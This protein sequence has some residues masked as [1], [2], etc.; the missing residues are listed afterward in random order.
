MMSAA[1]LPADSAPSPAPLRR[2]HILEM[3]NG[4]KLVGEYLGLEEGK[5]R[6]RSETLGEVLVIAADAKVTPLPAQ[7][8]DLSANKPAWVAATPP[9]TPPAPPK[10]VI[11]ATQGPKPPPTWQ[12]I[13]EF[14]FGYQSS[15]VS[16]SDSYLRA[17]VA[18]VKPNY[19]YR[20]YGKYIYG[21][22]DDVKSVDR[23]ESGFA[24]RHDLEGRW[25][26]RNDITYQNDRLQK[27]DAEV[28]GTAGFNYVLFNRPKFKFNAGPGVGVRYREPELGHTGY[29]S[30]VDFSEELSWQL[31]P[32]I[33]LSQNGSF[34][35][36]PNH[37]QNYRLS[38]TAVASGKLTD[39]VSV[40][41]RYEYLFDHARAVLLE[42]IDQRVFT[43]LGYTF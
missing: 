43:T 37:T 8:A 11:A 42:R 27:L 25:K 29:T 30:S 5:I 18:K 33:S 3:K 31:T 32:R 14:G 1:A 22:Q 17:E 40:N 4:E 36:D 39:Q 7:D 13:I 15:A 12:R 26:F 28:I 10:K 2:T 23:V 16:R 21:K 34:L 19:S 6:F 24:A 9:P 38:S 41:I 20:L 35:T